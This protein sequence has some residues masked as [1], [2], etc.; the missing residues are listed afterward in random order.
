MAVHNLGE[1]ISKLLMAKGCITEPIDDLQ[2]ELN[3]LPSLLSLIKSQAPNNSRLVEQALH[4][5]CGRSRSNV[6]KFSQKLISISSMNELSE[7][8]C[9]ES[10]SVAG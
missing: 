3:L 8:L 6:K 7:V 10:M 5:A 2:S 9:A 4:Q 1:E